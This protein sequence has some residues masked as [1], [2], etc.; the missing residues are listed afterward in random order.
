MNEGAGGQG[1]SSEELVCYL[2]LE[3]SQSEEHGGYSRQR[4]GVP[5]D[6]SH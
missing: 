1:C 5:R 3:L 4:V 6:A 2:N